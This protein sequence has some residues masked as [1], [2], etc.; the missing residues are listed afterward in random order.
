MIGDVPEARC[1]D[2]GFA[3]WLLSPVCFRLAGIHKLLNTA[4]RVATVNE[5]E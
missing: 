4:A 5:S 1:L 3:S 2:E